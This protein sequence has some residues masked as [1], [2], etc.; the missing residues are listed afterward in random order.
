MN[1][2]LTD[3]MIEEIKHDISSQRPKISNPGT[4]PSVWYSDCMRVA[5]NLG[6]IKGSANMAV[7]V[8]D[9]LKDN[10]GMLLLDT[11]SELS[12]RYL[13]SLK[14]EFIQDFIE[15]VCPQQQEDD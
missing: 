11:E 2:P 13:E 9:W 8:S 15:A 6:E 7:K 3:K 4:A 1:H 5:Y 14:D 12:H 10:V